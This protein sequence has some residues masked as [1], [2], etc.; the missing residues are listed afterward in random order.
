MTKNQK[1]FVLFVLALLGVFFT[2]WGLIKAKLFLAPLV[3]AIIL[4]FVVLPLAKRFEK[5][6][7]RGVSSLL[8]T[9]VILLV[10]LVFAY[11]IIYQLK[12]FTDDW[13]QIKEAMAPKI[14]HLEKFATSNFPMGESFE[15]LET[16]ISSFLKSRFSSA[17]QKTQSM[18]SSLFGILGNFLLTFVYV[19]FILRYRRMF[20]D[21]VLLIFD[22]SRSKKVNTIIEESIQ[23]APKYLQGKLLMIGLLFVLYS[24]GLGLSGVSYFILVSL[25]ASTLTLIPYLGN[26]I[27]VCIALTLGFLTTGDTNVL[28]GIVITFTVSQFIENYVLEPYVVG[29]KVDLHP[30][31]VILVVIASNFIWGILGMV[32]A[33]PVA[34]IFTVICSN[35]PQLRPIG[36]LLSKNSIKSQSKK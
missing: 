28:I 36:L 30:F 2:I 10:S 18:V 24:I 13:P 7:S 1:Y 8:S 35:I 9:F 27:A 19:F 16:K 34:G 31:F 17:L 26:I 21:F 33:V 5:V 23:V 22:D 20:K 29:D 25:L 32:I 6:M 15:N 3:I 14:D 12:L 4:S 11:L